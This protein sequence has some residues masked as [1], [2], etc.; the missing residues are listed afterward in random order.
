MLG[1]GEFPRF[2]AVVKIF[3][4]YVIKESQQDKTDTTRQ[5]SRTQFSSASEISDVPA[6]LIIQQTFLTS[7]QQE[8]RTRREPLPLRHTNPKLVYIYQ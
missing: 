1:T 4:K 2:A 3:N 6:Q 5:D 8:K 7:K